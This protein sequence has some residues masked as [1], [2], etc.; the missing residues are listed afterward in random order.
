MAGWSMVPGSGA[1]VW[2]V[3]VGVWGRVEEERAV[4]GARLGWA[5]QSGWA[6]RVVW[7]AS[8]LLEQRRHPR[9]LHRS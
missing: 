9:W 2:L 5:A 6:P 1:E 4:R 8:E 7:E 3:L